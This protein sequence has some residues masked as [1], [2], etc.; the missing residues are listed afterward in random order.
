MG[1][2]SDELGTKVYFDTNIIIYAIE[3]FAAFDDQIKALLQAMD[4]AEISV[5]TSELTLAEV[6]VKPIKD[7]DTTVQQLYRSF[8]TASPVLQMAPIARN[9]LEEAAHLRATTKL[10]IPDAIHLATA[11]L[12]G[13]DSFLT[14]D[15]LFKTV[16]TASVKLLS[17]VKL[18]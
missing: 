15:A 7:Q 11:N 5:I 8:L 2:V 4:D 9:I 1:R 17:D 10:K 13:C 12:N 6:L 18:I 16:G 3:G 14:N